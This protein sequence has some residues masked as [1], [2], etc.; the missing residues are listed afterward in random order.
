M[1]RN[2]FSAALAVLAVLCLLLLTGCADQ[3]VYTV[4]MVPT[5][6]GP[7][8]GQ[9]VFTRDSFPRLDGSTSAIPMAQAAASVLL[10]ESREEA[11]DL[12]RFS[13]T[14]PSYRELMTGGAD[15]ILAAEP[16]PG[17]WEE[18]AAAGFEWEMTPFAMDA[19]VFVVNEEN[20]V[21]NLTEEQIRDIYA[22]EITNWSQVGGEDL[23]IVPFQRSGEAGS[24]TVMEAL[25]MRGTPMGT[26]PADL[27]R[28]EMGD[29]MEAVAAYDNTAAAIG[30]T[31][32]YYAHAMTQAQG[33]KILS[34]DGVKPDAET[35]RSGAYPFRNYYYVVTAA[36]QDPDSPAKIL[37][38]WLLG[39]EGQYLAEHEGYISVHHT[40]DAARGEARRAGGAA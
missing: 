33:L 35:I 24:Q 28:G 23:E 5:G 19:L 15:V 3:P 26:A 30:Y 6:T 1:T 21:S 39:P 14:T 36:G 25:V 2:D 4:E 38:D 9:Y 13:K 16:A 18:K 31:L 22:G 34:V 29:L 37:C 32:Y 27:V 7:A 17:I 20:P 40:A 12:I 8:E 11:S 10:G